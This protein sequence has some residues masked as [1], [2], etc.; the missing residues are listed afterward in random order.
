VLIRP[1]GFGGVAVDLKTPGTIMVAALNSWCVESDG[2]FRRLV[3]D[4]AVGGR[5]AKFSDRQTVALLGRLCG[6]GSATP[7]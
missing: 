3:P 1:I 5:M 6:A 2:A 4:I 7:R